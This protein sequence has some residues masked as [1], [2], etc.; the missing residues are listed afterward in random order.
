AEIEEIR[1]TI[2]EIHR[3]LYK[4]DA[5][6]DG[7]IE[8]VDR[9]LSLFDQSLRNVAGEANRIRN[10]VSQIISM[11]PNQQIYLAIIMVLDILIWLV[12]A[13]LIYKAIVAWNRRHHIS[14]KF[15]QKVH[16]YSKG[17]IDVHS[18]NFDHITR[19]QPL[20]QYPPKYEYVQTGGLLPM[21]SKIDH[22]GKFETTY[23]ID[24]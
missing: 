17:I 23:G 12:V 19:E 8:N 7:A 14:E 22:K 10:D 24:R 13:L 5:H 3:T 6:L 11:F 18:K 20:S 2:T 4:I 15:V 1:R 21:Y 16:A 9:E